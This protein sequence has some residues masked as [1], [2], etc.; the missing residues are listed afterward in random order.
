MS[1]TQKQGYVHN[2]KKVHQNSKYP[3]KVLVL[4]G[5]TLTNKKT[6]VLL[7]WAIIFII[8]FSR[9]F[10]NDILMINVHDNILRHTNLNFAKTRFSTTSFTLLDNQSNAADHFGMSHKY[11]RQIL[12]IHSTCKFDCSKRFYVS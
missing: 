5:F 7:R 10:F 9:Y 1:T 6:Q 11:F 2:I 4:Q 12:L 8:F 3:K